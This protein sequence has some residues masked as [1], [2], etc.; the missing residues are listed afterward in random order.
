ME[1]TCR[2]RGRPPVRPDEAT[3]RL[4]IDAAAAEFRANGYAGAGM[5]A[6]ARRAGVSTKTLYRLVPTKADLF[7]SVIADRICRFMVEF[8]EQAVEGGD[9]ATTLERILVTLG[10]LILQ[11][12][13]M[14]INRLVIAECERFPEIGHAFYDVAVDKAAV[15]LARWLEKQAAAGLI[16]LEDPREAAGMLRGMMILEPQRAVMLGQRA[17]P[18]RAEIKARAKVC[19]GLFLK[20]CLPRS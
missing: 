14:A 17:N 13:T 9:I 5:N 4:I 2:G 19:A 1:Q 8:Q 10:E 18:G 6:V 11:P 16:E 12:E 15:A 3:I 20:G 7:K